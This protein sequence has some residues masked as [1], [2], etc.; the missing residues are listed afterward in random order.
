[1]RRFFKTVAL[2]SVFSTCEK[3]LGFL[4]RIFLSHSI[5]AEGIG[6][7]QVALSVFGLVY[8]FCSSGVPVTVSRLIT[9]DYAQ[10]NTKNVGKVISSG[11]FLSIAISLPTCIVFYIFRNSFSFLFADSRSLTIFLSI[12]PSLVFTCVYSVLRGVFWGKKDFLPCS[13]IDLLEEICMIVVG[14]LLISF[15]SSVYQGAFSA[16]IAVLVSYIF[17]FTLAVV[18]FFVRKNRL[19]SPFPQLKPLVKSSILAYTLY[20]IAF[21]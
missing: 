5:G 3:F 2:V 14:I 6:L 12:L 21:Y 16:G 15:S 17:S 4:Y 8:T 9:K 1:M 7:Y 13:I 20:I 11:L 19:S 18:V 10:K